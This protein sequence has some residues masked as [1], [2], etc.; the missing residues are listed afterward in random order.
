MILTLTLN[1]AVDQ[2]VTADGLVLGDVNRVRDAHLDP[3]GKGINASRMAHRLGWP[4]VAFGLL[5]GELGAIVRQ[6]LDAEGVQHHFVRIEGQTRLN[7]T[8]VD[9]GARTATSLYAQGPGA[10]PEQLETLDGLLR[11]WLPASKV[12]VLAGSLPPGAA[13]DTYARHIRAARAAG[14]KVILDADGEPLRLGTDAR[15]DLIKP[16]VAEAERLLGRSLPDLDAVV[17][18]ARELVERGIGTVV[19]SMGAEGA[20]CVQSGRAWRVIAP[21]VE[22]RSTVGSGDSM[23]AGLAVALARGDDLLEG[24][25]LGTAAGA[26]TA[27]TP[28]TGLGTAEGIAQLLPQVFVEALA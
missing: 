27:M 23:V 1:P 28:G 4:T 13:G 25:R 19:I 2:T 21:R 3:A 24:M 10:T 5:G 6:A 7:V 18:G 8:I 9:A 20:V 22:R 12:L 14:V 26:A 11:F 15:P 16:N 17:S